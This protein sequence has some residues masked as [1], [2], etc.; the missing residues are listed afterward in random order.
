MR[1]CGL[2][3]RA[4]NPLSSWSDY[5]YNTTTTYIY[6]VVMYTHEYPVYKIR[7][8]WWFNTVCLLFSNKV[9]ISWWRSGNS[10]LSFFFSCYSKVR[11]GDKHSGCSLWGLT[12]FSDGI[13]DRYSIYIYIYITHILY[14]IYIVVLLI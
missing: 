6:H 9:Q 5:L 4:R 12:I 10:F 2:E 7:L 3:K 14:N 11:A 13:S 8:S 1:G